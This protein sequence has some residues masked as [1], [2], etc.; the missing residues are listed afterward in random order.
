MQQTQAPDS[1]AVVLACALP[2]TCMPL[3]GGAADK[4]GNRYEVRWTVYC[5]LRVLDEDVRAI[6]LEAVGPEG[7][8]VEFYLTRLDGSREYHQV[9]RQRAKGPWTMS[10][11]ASEGILAHFGNK[12]SS[13]S[14]RCVFVSMISAGELCE[15]CERAGNAD[16]AGLFESE[17]LGAAGVRDSFR[18]LRESWGDC[19]PAEAFERLRRVQVRT[20]DE[21]TLQESVELRLRALVA[22]DAANAAHTLAA[23]ALDSIHKE[24]TTDAIWAHLR[25]RGFERRV[26]SNDPHVHHAV[27]AANERYTRSVHVR[28]IQGQAIPRDE[29]DEIVAGL[30][31]QQGE[32]VVL[33]AGDAGSGKS[34]VV[35]QVLERL[36]DQEGWL[37]LGLSM[38]VCEPVQTTRQLGEKMDLPESPP[39][40]LANLA[41]DRPCLLVV[42]QLD[43]LSMSSG[44]N[45]HLFDRVDEMIRQAAAYREMRVVLACRTFDLKNDD[46]FHRL[47]GEGG[48]ARQVEVSTLSAERVRQ[49]VAAAG[50][51]A[52]GLDEDQVGFL[53]I[54][55]HLKLLTELAAADPTVWPLDTLTREALYEQFW[56]RKRAAVERRLGRSPRW[57]PLLDTAL[58]RM[59]ASRELS[60]P[61]SALDDEFPKDLEAL[62]SEGVLFRIGA[63]IRFFHETFFD[64]A[65]ARRFVGRG[66]RLL[67]FLKQS[68]QHLFLRATVLQV[69]T[70]QR[71]RDHRAYLRDLR[72]I[73]TSTEVRFHIRHLVFR[74]LA[75]LTDPWEQEWQIVRTVTGDDDPQV[76]HHAWG[77]CMS[78]P[79]FRLLDQLGYIEGE[80]RCDDEARVTRMVDYLRARIEDEPDRVAEIVQSFVDQPDPWPT[81]ARDVLRFAKGYRSHRFVELYRR[82]LEKGIYSVDVFPLEHDD[83][84]FLFG[85]LAQEQP[86]WAIEVL[87]L[88]LSE[89]LR[90][91]HEERGTVKGVLGDVSQQQ[92][93]IVGLARREPTRFV[94]AILPISLRLLELSADREGEKPGGTPS[95]PGR[96]PCFELVWSV[97]SSMD[98]SRGCVIWPAN[99]RMYLRAMSRPSRSI[100]TIRRPASGSPRGTPPMV[101]DTPTRPWS[102]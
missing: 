16:D 100:S 2:S 37:V 77:V 29:V 36:R 75:Q 96:S 55:L 10:V 59:T 87:A 46:R 69:L 30:M 58:D 101:S 91:L 76:A 81:R 42:D 102:S 38:D 6:R 71:V 27:E 32:R 60:V 80:L 70:Y 85:R 34:G 89:R 1:P 4:I 11:M 92:R 21:Q 73:L 64:F 47:V 45:P 97:R 78:A 44:R 67:D 19:A 84:F 62:L 15:L 31:D 17:F 50:I 26:W 68:G 95:G 24:L 79:W 88:W 65:F 39:V 90:V 82:L 43:A 99:S 18:K 56:E 72:A 28:D 86:A 13:A 98:C 51:D 12:L 40:V 94:A 14:A 49:T 35:V 53:S 66:Q 57:Q 20:V 7:D 74:W 61:A 41:G 33:V 54:P 3:P 22:G 48:I 25:A 8:G 63:R 5:M 93:Q 83:G 23:L 9:K 52:D